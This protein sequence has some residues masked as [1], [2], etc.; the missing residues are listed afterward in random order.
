MTSGGD[1]ILRLF[2]RSS[3]VNLVDL[4]KNSKLSKLLINKQ[5]ET[6]KTANSHSIGKGSLIHHNISPWN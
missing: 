4:C 1:C 2:T 5:S 3:S 6:F